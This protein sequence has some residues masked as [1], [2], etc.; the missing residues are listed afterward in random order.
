[1]GRFKVEH[2]DFDYVGREQVG[3]FGTGTRAPK[4]SMERTSHGDAYLWGWFAGVGILG[5]YKA[6]RARPSLG[7]P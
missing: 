5:T 4:R 6:P 1:M 3:G 7:G 2:E